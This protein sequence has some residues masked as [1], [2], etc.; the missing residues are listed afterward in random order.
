[1]LNSY[2]KNPRHLTENLLALCRWL[3]CWYTRFGFLCRRWES[4]A[5][6]MK[7]MVCPSSWV[8]TSWGSISGAVEASR[9]AQA[10]VFLLQRAA[11]RAW[12]NSWALVGWRVTVMSSPLHLLSE[13]LMTGDSSSSST[14]R[15]KGNGSHV[16]KDFTR[17]E[18]ARQVLQIQDLFE[19]LRFDLL[20]NKL[21]SFTLSGF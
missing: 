18:E 1:M 15:G 6:I 21:V 7:L 11:F 20:V 9:S 5:C 4:S 12:P 14:W 19:V 16:Y 17:A 10:T 3:R 8:L 2:K 13:S